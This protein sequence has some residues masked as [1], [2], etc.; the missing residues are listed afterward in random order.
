MSE[1]AICEGRLVAWVPGHLRNPLNGNRVHWSVAAKERKGWRQRTMLCCMDAMRR[2]GIKPGR[3]DGG[4]WHPKWPKLIVLTAYVW[5]LYDED[6][7]AASLKSVVDG[8]VDAKLIHDDGPTSGH[9]VRRRQVINR[10]HR[11]VEV[12]V[13][14]AS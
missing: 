5:N 10:K 6:G 1:V 3:E 14:H 8:L 12:V 13:E 9:T 2:A 4:I 11:G 7:L